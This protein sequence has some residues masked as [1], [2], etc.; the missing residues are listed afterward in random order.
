MR[1]SNCGE[2]TDEDYDP[3]PPPYMVYGT[4]KPNSQISIRL[5]KT[6][7]IVIET[8]VSGRWM[9]DLNQ[10]EYGYKR[11]KYVYINEKRYKIKG[12]KMEVNK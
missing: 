4:S 10:F 2:E 9:L 7:E 8:D 11:Y 1:C 3:G 6:Q 5:G 12:S